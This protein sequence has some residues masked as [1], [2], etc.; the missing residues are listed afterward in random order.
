ME[1]LPVTTPPPPK[2]AAFRSAL[3][4]FNEKAGSVAAGDGERLAAALTEAGIERYA[5]LAPDKIKRALFERAKSFDV[6]IVLGGDGTA[7]AAAA[8][9]HADGPPLLLLPG[10]TLNILPKA[11]LGNLAWPEALAAALDHGVVKRL[12]AGRANGERFFVAAMF[13]A[14]TMLARAREA[15]REGRFLA[16]LG[17]VRH[18]LKRAFMRGLRAR[19]GQERLRKAEAIGVLC[20]AFTGAIEGEGLEWVR[21]KA[22]HF[23][24]LARVSVRALGEGWRDDPVV[25]IGHCKTGDIVATAGVIPATLDG[26]PRTFLSHVRITYDP[27]GV[28]VLTLEPEPRH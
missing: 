17:R 9:A 24:D 13:G 18:F 22:T 28:R 11:L 10:G 3:V 27:K 1:P 25:E 23:I 20:P 19:N 15:M 7:R 2:A 6:I 12:P 4:L 26:E 21:L 14:P 16:A 8:M 5:I